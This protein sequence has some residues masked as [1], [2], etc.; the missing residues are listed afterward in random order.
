MLMRNR[1]DKKC[2]QWEV[3]SDW[4]Q[5]MRSIT[6]EKKNRVNW[7][8]CA[9]VNHWMTPC[10]WLNAW[11][12][13]WMTIE[14]CKKMIITILLAHIDDPQSMVTV[15]RVEWIRWPHRVHIHQHLGLRLHTG[16]LI[17]T[18]SK[19][20]FIPLYRST[21]YLFISRKRRM[22]QFGF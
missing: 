21:R 12:C 14:W 5:G 17:I 3:E 9:C 15:S 16:R 1:V 18:S 2:S 4:L 10:S 7:A 13:S 8:K 20:N 22:Q 6:R 11:S 19:T